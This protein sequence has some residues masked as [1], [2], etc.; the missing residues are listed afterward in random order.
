MRMRY[1][2]PAFLV[3]V[4]PALAQ[5]GVAVSA[6]QRPI[7]AVEHVL[8]ISI[9]GLRPDRALWADM[10][11]L[12]SMAKNG[13]YTFWARTT[14]VSIT[15]PSHTSMLTG[16]TPRKHGVEWNSDLPLNEP[17]YPRVPTVFELAKNAGYTTALIAGKS[18]FSTLA[19]P[20]TVTW[21]AI[22]E[23]KNSSGS[24]ATVTAAAARIIEEHKPALIVVHYNEVDSTGH[25]YGWGSAEQFAKIEETDR[26]LGH[27]LEA[28]DRAGI[29]NSTTII[30]SADHGGA[31]RTHGP[32]D[33]RSRHIPWIAS[34]AG[35]V[36]G[37]DLTQ[38]ADLQVDT[39]D[40]CV[41][42]CW[43]LGLPL[44]PYFDGKPV[45]SA[46]DIP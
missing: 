31:G 10:P 35:V 9:D 28:L 17:V 32:D 3:W 4:S 33:A 6:P 44:L 13:A 40:T 24:H 2:L 16:V 45:L 19:K 43:L 1:L 18:K 14:A 29:R 22:P 27:L 26:E 5:F 20:G 46:F 8:I 39:E 12:R 36:K 30:V 23:A 37:I 38:D 7:P 11:V 15:L 34:G 42:A 25:K 41:T 21:T